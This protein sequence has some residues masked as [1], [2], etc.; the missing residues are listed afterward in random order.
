MGLDLK[1]FLEDVLHDPEAFALFD[2]D[3][4]QLVASADL[5]EGQLVRAYMNRGRAPFRSWP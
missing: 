3:D 2:L 1:T 4:L 5:D